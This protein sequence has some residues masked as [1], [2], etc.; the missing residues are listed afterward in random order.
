MELG[1]RQKRRLKEEVDPAVSWID[2]GM[3][4]GRLHNAYASGVEPKLLSSWGNQSVDPT[5]V[6]PRKWGKE[7]EQRCNNS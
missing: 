7:R 1:D 4:P 5:Q 3:G 6:G 2:P